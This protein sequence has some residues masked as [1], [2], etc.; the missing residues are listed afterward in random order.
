MFESI[1]EN[2][3]KN[4]FRQIKLPPFLNE[5]P[6]EIINRRLPKNRLIDDLMIEVR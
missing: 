2:R 3:K 1:K 5:D 4:R 6:E